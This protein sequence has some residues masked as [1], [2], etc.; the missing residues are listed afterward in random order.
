MDKPDMQVFC[1]NAHRALASEIC[2]YLHIPV[3][4]AF[5]GRF[6]D[7]EIDVK[8]END[9]RGVDLFVIQP[10][11]PP[12]NES[13]MELLILIDC[14]K[15]AS[16][17]RITAVIPYFGYARKDRKDEGR[18]PITAKLVANLL[19]EAG[20]DR[21]LTIDLHATQIQGFFDIPVD[22]MFASPV[23]TRYFREMRIPKLVV[24]S[25]D[26]GG[27]KMAR[28]Y[29]KHLEGDLVIVDKRRGGPEQTEVMNII[30]EVRDRN[31]LIIDD[32]ISTAGTIT[33]AAAALKRAG[34]QDVYLAATHAVFCGEAVARLRAAPVQ[35][36]V[37]TNTIPL[38]GKVPSGLVEVLSVAPL[39]GEAMR[40]IHLNQSISALF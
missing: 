28:A 40:R 35:K 38:G 12:V 25:S 15:R 1:G 32:M 26:V 29:A 6:P 36:V 18:V 37:V 23:L 13:L 2:E 4:R 33:Q 14:F 39:L 10:T 11:C 21:I 7:G 17:A 34:A 31:V 5:V 16:A 3:G 24:A 22:H 19:T 20:A 8:V 30:G 27:V 9:V